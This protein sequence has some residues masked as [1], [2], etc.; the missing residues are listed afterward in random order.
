MESELASARGVVD[1]DDSTVG[2]DEM[3]MANMSSDEMTT[4]LSSLS[5]HA[6]FLLEMDRQRRIP[7]W[8]ESD[9]FVGNVTTHSGCESERFLILKMP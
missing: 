7:G 4:T 1:V 6:S 2:S 8:C 9:E 5:W 3:L